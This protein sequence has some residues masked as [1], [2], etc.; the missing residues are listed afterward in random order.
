MF[1]NAYTRISAREVG[2]GIRV[3]SLCPGSIATDM[4]SHRGSG[5]IYD[6]ALLP[7]TLAR[8]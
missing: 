7:V 2:R 4:S 8:S 5:T 6:G 3:N 1:L